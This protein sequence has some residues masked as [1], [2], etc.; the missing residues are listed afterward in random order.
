MVM[1]AKPA[2]ALTPGQRK[3]AV[4]DQPLPLYRLDP[5]IAFTD[6]PLADSTGTGRTV[7][8]A[9]RAPLAAPVPP[10]SPHIQDGLASDTCAS[11]HAAHTA[12]GP[13]LLQTA[14]PQATICFTCHDGTGATTDVQSDW[15]SSSIPANDPSTSSWYSHP[16]TDDT[17]HTS[18][19]D[20]EF[21]GVLNRHAVCA[22]CHQPHLA[23]DTASVGSVA[24]W[25]SSGAIAAARAVEVANGAAGSAP[26]YTWKLGS[27]FEYELCFK[28][29]S[30]YTTLPAQDPS[31]PS[32]WALDKAVEL[33]PANVSYHPIE[34]AGKNQTTEMALSLSG[35]SPYKL[36]QFTT[37]STIRCENCHGDS[38]AAD[39]LN[40][41]DPGSQLDNHSSPNRG[42]LIA[43]Y[44]DR[45]LNPR[46]AYQAQDFALCYVC[47]AEAPMVDDSADFRADT[48]FNWHGY[49]LNNISGN[50]LG[51]LDIDVP[52]AGPGNAICAEC[53]FRIHGSALAVNGQPPATGLVNFAPN[54]QALPGSPMFKAA[55]ATTAG[56]CTLVCHGKAH[57]GFDYGVPP[58]P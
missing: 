22:D 50:G 20:D 46:G 30:G 35:T 26:T 15:S 23:N 4:V 39:P 34:A 54:V 49:H 41:P 43:P 40:P 11:C 28:C 18:A 1:E 58:T 31:H 8:Y 42:I 32:R 37:D 3:G 56:T 13:M 52:G 45:E 9:L 16:A 48:K 6:L 10:G 12:K 19:L 38:A 57:L 27:T 55:T 36:W 53:H 25:T 24:G 44:Q 47:H 7:A 14:G 29:H 21:G 33:N 2:L 5:S 51:G 17:G